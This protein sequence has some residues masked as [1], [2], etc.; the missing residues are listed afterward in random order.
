MP[1]IKIF[2]IDDDQIFVFLTKKTIESTGIKTEVRV[3]GD[4]EEA[5]DYLRE[6]SQTIELLPDI[7]CLDLSMPIMDGWEFLE[8][9]ILLKPKIEK[10]VILYLVSSSISPH[11]IER[12]KNISVVS[13]FIIKPVVKEKIIELFQTFNQPQ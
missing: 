5:I 11:D 9:F 4:G 8:E 2:L 1:P 7:I 6:A 3:F 12:A 13:D 10:K